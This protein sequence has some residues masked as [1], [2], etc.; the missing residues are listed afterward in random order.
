MRCK[1]TTIFKS[2]KPSFKKNQTFTSFIFDK[3][4]NQQ[5]KTKTFF[6]FF[7]LN[8]IIKLKSLSILILIRV[9]K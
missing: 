4:D 5:Y 1:Y 7:Y 2:S 9:S 6:P 3:T 8:L